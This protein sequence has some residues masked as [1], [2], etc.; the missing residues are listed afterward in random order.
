MWRRT[1]REPPPDLRHDW[2]R[3]HVIEWNTG[4][5]D[6]VTFWREF[7]RSQGGQWSDEYRDRI[8]LHLPMQDHLA[9]ILSHVNRNPVDVLDVGAGPLTAVG[10]TLPG[11]AVR[12]VAVDALGKQYDALLREF[13][14]TLLRLLLTWSTAVI[15]WIT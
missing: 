9:T 15:A 3:H 11:K 12:L 14:V 6:E 13:G 4:I 7:F 8:D 10:K 5:T 1:R 2:L